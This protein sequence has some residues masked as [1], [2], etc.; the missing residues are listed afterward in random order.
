ML[1]VCE[2]AFMKGNKKKRNRDHER[3]SKNKDDTVDQSICSF[4]RQNK[5]TGQQRLQVPTANLSERLGPITQFFTNS[6]FIKL[7]NKR[8]ILHGSRNPA[9]TPA[10]SPSGTT[11]AASLFLSRLSSSS[12]NSFKAAASDSFCCFWAFEFEFDKAPSPSSYPRPIH[13]AERT[14]PRATIH[15]GQ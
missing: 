3:A 4:H 15:S 1:R 11:S 8:T 2:D 7:I 5:L 14:R 12:A 9:D 6:S 10:R 13:A